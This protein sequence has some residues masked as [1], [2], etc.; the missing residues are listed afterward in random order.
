MVDG[1]YDK[2]MVVCG[3]YVTQTATVVV[4]IIHGARMATVDC[5]MDGWDEKKK[6]PLPRKQ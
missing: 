5:S 6:L 1:D 4:V 3:Y 2:E